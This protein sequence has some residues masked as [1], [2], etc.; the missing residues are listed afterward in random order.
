MIDRAAVGLG[1]V[2]MHLNAKLNW[3]KILEDMISDFDEKVLSNR[4]K[5]ILEKVKI[6]NYN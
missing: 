2:F 6:K 1:S 5:S 4:Q 3:H